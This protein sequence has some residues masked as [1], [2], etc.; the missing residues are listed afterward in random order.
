MRMLCECKGDVC[1]NAPLGRRLRP[2]A[3]RGD[4]AI[5]RAIRGLAF[6]EQRPRNLN[7]GDG[8]KCSDPPKRGSGERI[9]EILSFYPFARRSDGRH[10]AG[11]VPLSA[12]VEVRRPAQQIAYLLTR[13][14][15]AAAISEL[16]GR[17]DGTKLQRREALSLISFFGSGH[18]SN[19]T[20]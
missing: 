6:A 16:R 14:I 18:H 3:G 2:P 4:A 15:R 12:V 1:V 20:I 9:S 11:H 17:T 10:T 13:H 7:V 8:I 5:G 19:T